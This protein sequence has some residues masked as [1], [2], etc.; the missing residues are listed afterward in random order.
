ML[1]SAFYQGPNVEV[2]KNQLLLIP[3]IPDFRSHE[4]LFQQ[5]YLFEFFS[6]FDF[7]LCLGSIGRKMVENARFD[8]F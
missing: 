3:C 8:E 1:L 2:G 7:F 5:H 4:Y 6:T